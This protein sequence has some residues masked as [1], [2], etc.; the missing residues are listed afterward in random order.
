MKRFPFILAAL[1]AFVLGF[2]SCTKED[3]PEVVTGGSV[4]FSTR[5]S[6]S[7]QLGGELVPV[8]A[9]GFLDENHC[10]KVYEVTVDD[11][12]KVPADGYL[13]RNVKLPEEVDDTYTILIHGNF[14]PLFGLYEWHM[15]TWEKKEVHNGGSTN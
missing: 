11:K 9:P 4:V 5:T 12:C 6:Y 2:V 8:K 15:V 13:A 1:M 10:V 7:G 14:N 3:V